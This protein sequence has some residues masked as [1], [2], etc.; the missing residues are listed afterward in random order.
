[1]LFVTHARYHTP[2]FNP[3][4]G[5]TKKGV[6]QSH[7]NTSRTHH[8]T[9]TRVAPGPPGILFHS[10]GTIINYPHPLFSLVSKHVCFLAVAHQN[11][12]LKNANHTANQRNSQHHSNQRPTSGN[13]ARPFLPTNVSQLKDR[14]SRQAPQQPNMD[15]LK[16]PDQGAAG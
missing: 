2:Q 9:P 12:G 1:M 13:S 10:T 6:T 7:P 3:H 8:H 15:F 16:V 11:G 4:S 5:P 14:G